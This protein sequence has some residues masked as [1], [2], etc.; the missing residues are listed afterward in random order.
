VLPTPLVE[1]EVVTNLVSVQLAASH[2]ES[3]IQQSVEPVSIIIVTAYDGV[4][5]YRVA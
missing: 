5:T 3:G 1:L 4:P 2:V